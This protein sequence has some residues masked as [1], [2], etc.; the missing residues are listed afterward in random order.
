MPTQPRTRRSKRA[1]CPPM[2][3]PLTV[4]LV[5]RDRRVVEVAVEDGNLLDRLRQ[6]HVL[7]VDLVVAVVLGDL[8][9]VAESDRVE[10][11]CELAVAAEDAAAHV[12]L[13][14]PRVAL[15]RGHSVV[16]RVLRRHDSDAVGRARGCAERAADALLEPV[17]VPVQPVPSA[18]ARVHG[19]LVLRVLLR[20]RLVEQLA[21]RDGEALERVERLR[22][23]ISTMRKA[24]TRALIVA[25]GS[26]TFQPKRI[27]WSYR[28]RGTEARIQMKSSKKT[29][30][31]SMNQIGPYGSSCSSHGKCQPP[32]NSVTIS[33]ESTIRLM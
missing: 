18:E 33:A 13:V 25:T 23:Q 20:D 24:V 7:R 16:G 32:K 31:L 3:R 30:S 12:D 17:L 14:D 26:S 8:V 4:L 5:E 27:S 15:A 9:L 11:A 22:H 28:S 6:Q 1:H 10:R 29:S 21:E 2:R 19:F